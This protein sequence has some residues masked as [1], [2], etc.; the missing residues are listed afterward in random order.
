MAAA[1]ERGCDDKE[2]QDRFRAWLRSD[3]SIKGLNHPLFMFAKE[4][5]QAGI[6]AAAERPEFSPEQM[7]EIN[8]KIDEK[9]AAKKAVEEIE[10]EKRRA[11]EECERTTHVDDPLCSCEKCQPDFWSCKV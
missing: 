10:A 9:I 2:I 5:T 4:F 8:R 1:Q 11:E 7:A 6:L 3:R